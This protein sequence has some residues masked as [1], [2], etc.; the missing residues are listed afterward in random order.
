MA[1]SAS[2]EDPARIYVYARRDTAAHSWLAISCDSS[3]VAEVKHGA[4]FA[5]NLALGRHAF[6]V[7]GGLPLF[8]DAASGKEI[9]VRLDWNYGTGRSPIAVLSKVNPT[10]AQREMKYLSYIAVKRSHSSLVPKTD[11]RKEIQP[12]LRMR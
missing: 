8:I 5:V 12:Q 6:F 1:L 10:D 9:Y 4:F 11:P 2:A 3:V 7:D